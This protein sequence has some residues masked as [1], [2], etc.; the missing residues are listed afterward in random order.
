ML[1]FFCLDCSSWTSKSVTG[2]IK[3][4][5]QD[6]Y[7]K[8]LGKRIVHGV[9]GFGH[10]LVVLA[11]PVCRQCNVSV[12][13][14]YEF[15]SEG[16]A[17]EYWKKFRHQHH[18]KSGDLLSNTITFVTAGYIYF[19]YCMQVVKCVHTLGAVNHA[20]WNLV[21]GHTTTATKDMLQSIKHCRTA[22]EDNTGSSSNQA[23]VTVA[24]ETAT[25]TITRAL[26]TN[27]VQYV[28]ASECS[29]LTLQKMLTVL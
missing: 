14:D 19:L 15:C 24:M 4:Y 5:N 3:L 16:C 11:T 9:K 7:T 18:Q 17:L 20:M 26:E 22:D 12:H 10:Y 21:G 1:M 28:T 2:P 6:E 8:S 23:A 29:A 27:Q 25:T 13:P